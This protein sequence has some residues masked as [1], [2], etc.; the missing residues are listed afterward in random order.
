MK[1]QLKHKTMLVST[2]RM[3]RKVENQNLGALVSKY[4]DDSF[5]PESRITSIVASTYAKAESIPKRKSV[6]K[7]IIAQKFGN[8]IVSTAAGYAINAKPILLI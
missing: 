5:M 6:K 1:L 8:V 2:P 3:H 7:I 4:F